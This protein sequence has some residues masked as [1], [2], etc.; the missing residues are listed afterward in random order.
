[1]GT[2]PLSVRRM[3]PISS[4]H[5]EIDYESN[6]PCP[7]TPCIICHAHNMSN[8][9]NCEQSVCEKD[10][11]THQPNP[12]KC[13]PWKVAK[14]P[15]VGRVLIA[16]RDIRPWEAVLTDTAMVQAPDDSPVCV[17]CLGAVSGDAVCARC[18]WPVCGV[19]CQEEEV[20]EEECRIFQKNNVAPC[21]ENFDNNH[22]L[23]TALAVLRVLLVK[24]KDPENWVKVE[25]LMD[26]WEERENDSK[27]AEAV[28]MMC[29][30]FQKICKLEW[31]TLR[32]V[33]HSFGV[34]KTNSVSLI[35]CQGRSLY[36][37]V[38]ILSHSCSANLEPVSNPAKTITLRAKTHILAG[39]QLTMRYTNFIDSK[40][41][42]QAKLQNDWLF[43]CNCKR[44]GDVTELGS[45]F[46][47]LQCPCGGYYYQT[48]KDPQRHATICSKCEK[49]M[50]FTD[51]FLE[52]KEI[53][54]NLF[55]ASAQNISELCDVI[56]AD[57]EI[58]DTFF[59]KTKACMKYVDIF[60]NTDNQEILENVVHH[61]KIVLNTLQL[62]D[63]GISKLMGSYLM[64]LAECQQKLLKIMKAEGVI[65]LPDLQ[66]AV[67][68]LTR[69]KLTAVKMLSQHVI[70]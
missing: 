20:H 28:N 12:G 17:G 40:W 10:I 38:S 39:E 65:S 3:S 25:A 9:T 44:C 5:T 6:G 52:F 22:W 4:Q 60:Q 46:S 33:Q 1:M 64:V 15:V 26:H 47:S 41:S 59:M 23:Y 51:K 18:K 19:Q 57:K 31:V 45:H 66:R 14:L 8:C 13:Q 11:Q 58:H 24:K 36:P 29:Q 32:D 30:F 62:V 54:S 61:V 49:C 2:C 50:D 21:I 27:V 7:T 70:M 42:I 63:S 43:V 69:T 35:S 37:L 56:E 48:I 67:K 34:L 16:S 68:E 55:S 53:E